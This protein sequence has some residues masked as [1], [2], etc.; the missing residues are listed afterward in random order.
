MSAETL[1]IL[2]N[3]DA[4]AVNQDPLGKQAERLA[5][6]GDLELWVKPLSHGARAFGVFNRS[7]EAREVRFAWAELGLASKP[8]SLRDV[9]EHRDAPPAPEGWQGRIPAHG[10]ALLIAR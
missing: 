2:T 3:R 4:I 8:L 5:Q 1:D 9:W 6:R 7:S 10:V